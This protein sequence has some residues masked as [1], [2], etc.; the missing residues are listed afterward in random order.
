MGQKDL[1]EALEKLIRELDQIDENDTK[2]REKLKQVVGA[3]EKKLNEPENKE[4]HDQ[5]L[6]KLN[7]QKVHFEV[8][9]PIISGA[10]DKIINI[11]AKLGI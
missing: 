3:I 6:D 2:S 5:L 7:E 10:L 1:E 4:H 11:L 9:H 8:E